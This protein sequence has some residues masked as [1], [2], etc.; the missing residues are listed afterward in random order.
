MERAEFLFQI[1][2][3]TFELFQRENSDLSIFVRLFNLPMIEID[4]VHGLS[5]FTEVSTGKRLT[6]KMPYV[7]VLDECPLFIFVKSPRSGRTSER[8]SQH[9]VK[10]QNIFAHAIQNPGRYV[11]QRF[12]ELLLCKHDERFARAAFTVS[13]CYT[14]STQE[15]ITDLT[16]IIIHSQ[17]STESDLSLKASTRK[18]ETSTMTRTPLAPDP[19]ET[20]DR[21]IFYFDKN[22]LLEENRVLAE[23]IRQL[24]DMVQRLKE[25]INNYQGNQEQNYYNNSP[26]RR[27]VNTEP[28][29]T[30]GGR[31]DYVYHPPGL[32][33][34]KRLTPRKKATMKAKT[35]TNYKGI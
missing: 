2:F 14:S 25:I 18:K 9:K 5:D 30:V 10:L 23:E 19:P 3:E 17:S 29:R 35:N 32:Q 13:V 31:S 15:S 33:T 34:T 4:K 27:V 21:S 8:R 1:F 7:E 20:R 12:T 22:E 26:K 11:Q 16:P 24:T 6:L 28:I